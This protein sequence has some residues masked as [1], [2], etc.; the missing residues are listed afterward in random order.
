M[1][2]REGV[3][4]IATHAGDDPERATIPFALGNAAL[5]MDEPGI[6]VLQ[7]DGVLLAKKGYAESLHASG[8][9]PL[10][11]LVD[12]FMELGGRIL[13]CSPC[14]KERN[15]D[16]SE[17]IDKSEVV[18]GATILSECLNSKAVLSY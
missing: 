7:A 9:D 14:I 17:L 1:E 15:I 11:K 3:V 2:E 8:F 5:A 10:K 4:I 13:V 18:A 12:S 16:P 6:I